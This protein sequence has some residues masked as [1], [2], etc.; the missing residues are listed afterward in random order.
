MC[1]VDTAITDPTIEVNLGSIQTCL[2]V[3]IVPILVGNKEVIW[4]EKKKTIKMRFF[5]CIKLDRLL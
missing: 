4:G 2:R 1:T 5:K 3:T